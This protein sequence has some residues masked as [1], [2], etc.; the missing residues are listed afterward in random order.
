VRYQ[1]HKTSLLPYLAI[2]SREHQITP[3]RVI[4]SIITSL[5]S[6]R[7]LILQMKKMSQECPRLKV[8]KG[9][10]NKGNLGLG[11]SEKVEIILRRSEGF[12]FGLLYIRH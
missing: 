6:S 7:V 12:G 11:T 4:F 9:T 5:C 3:P 10:L 2:N 8:V 1:K